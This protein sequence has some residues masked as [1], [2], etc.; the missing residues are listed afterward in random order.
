MIANFLKAEQRKIQAKFSAVFSSTDTRN[1]N[2]LAKTILSIIDLGVLAQK[3]SK[4]KDEDK[5]RADMQKF[6]RQKTIINKFLDFAKDQKE[7]R[8]TREAQVSMPVL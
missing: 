8:K 4:V 3:I 7:R 6:V 2:A 1:K 5:S